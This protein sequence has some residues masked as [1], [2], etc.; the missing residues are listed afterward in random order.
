MGSLLKALALP[1]TV[2]KKVD[3]TN[4]DS[5]KLKLLAAHL[6]VPEDEHERLAA[7]P[8][9]KQ[10]EA[11]IQRAPLSPAVRDYLLGTTEYVNRLR[12]IVRAAKLPK[13]REE[14]LL[15]LDKEDLL[16]AVVDNGGKHG[17]AGQKLQSVISVAMLSEGWDA[18][19]VT[20]IMWPVSVHESAAVGAGYRPRASAGGLRPGREQAFPAGVRERLRGPAL[21]LRRCHGRGD[22][23]AATPSPARRS[24]P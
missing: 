9:E 6:G 4:K 24:S 20:H 8:T 2:R 15:A 23:A 21:C 7:S 18:K 1:E 14:R 19:N 11:L 17:Q 16:R 3:D 12:E 10:L 13:D 22:G 5:D